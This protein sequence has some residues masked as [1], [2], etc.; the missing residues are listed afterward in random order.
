MPAAIALQYTAMSIRGNL[1]RAL[2]ERTAARH[3]PGELLERLDRTGAAITERLAAAPDT[4]AN[5]E[6]AVHVIGIE[7]WGQRRLRIALGEPPV[8]DEYD[9]YRPGED[10]DMAALAALFAETRQ[11][12]LALATLAVRLPESVTAPH[13]ELG[14]LTVPGWLIYLEGHAERETRFR[15]RG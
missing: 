8:R 2:I 12:T 3:T 4:P 11:Q 5:R 6:A 14:D 10:Q 7:R 13:N 9:A 15:L 1:Q